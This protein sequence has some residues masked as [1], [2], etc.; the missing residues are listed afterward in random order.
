[1]SPLLIAAVVL[2]AVAAPA[3]AQSPR[4]GPRMQRILGPQQPDQPT[5]Q[6]QAPAPPAVD[7]LDPWLKRFHELLPRSA[8][9]FGEFNAP[10]LAEA[11]TQ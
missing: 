6:P 10:A 2:I 5:E 4:L 9:A 7:G 8:A 3:S 11:G 1:V